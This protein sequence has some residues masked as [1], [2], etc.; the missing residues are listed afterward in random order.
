MLFSMLYR[1]VSSKSKKLLNK[2]I[3]VK[4]PT[5]P[6]AGGLLSYRLHKAFLRNYWVKPKVS[7]FLFNELT[8]LLGCMAEAPERLAKLIRFTVW[9]RTGSPRRYGDD[10]N[11]SFF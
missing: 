2:K 6:W 3:E 1:T 4:K 11:I 8:V 10:F 7:D 9:A 5:K